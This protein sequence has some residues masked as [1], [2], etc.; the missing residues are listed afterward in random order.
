MNKDLIPRAAR[1]SRMA[2]A[3][4]YHKRPGKARSQRSGRAQERIVAAEAGP[5]VP[6]VHQARRIMERVQETRDRGA[7]REWNAAVTEIAPSVPT[8]K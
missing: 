6:L 4:S 2:D 5:E 7:S 1:S 3:F 8:F